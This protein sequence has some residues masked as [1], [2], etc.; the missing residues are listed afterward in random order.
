VFNSVG[1]EKG[2]Y[3]IRR[4]N[5][6]TK[7][8]LYELIKVKRYGDIRD[9]YEVTA[10]L[11]GYYNKETGTALIHDGYGITVKPEIVKNATGFFSRFLKFGKND[12]S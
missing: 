4:N 1:L 12:G 8:L 7:V 5:E 3:I 10:N 6:H 9:M 2:D 11:C